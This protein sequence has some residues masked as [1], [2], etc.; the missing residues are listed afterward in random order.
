MTKK[1]TRDF[2]KKIGH[3]LYLR[4]KILNLTQKNIAD[5]LNVSFQSVQKYEKGENA[6][7][8]YNLYKVA[9]F[10]GVDLNYFFQDIKENSIIKIISTY[11]EID[12]KLQNLL[13]NFT[14]I[15]DKKVAQRIEDLIVSINN[16]Q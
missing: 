10:L 7:S 11:H 12:L 9:V 3:R 16:E 4:R 8:P 13:K 1:D 6:L 2:N 14:K 5:V 15:K